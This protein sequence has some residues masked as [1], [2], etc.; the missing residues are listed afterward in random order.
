MDPYLAV[1]ELIGPLS[2]SI[3]SELRILLRLLI[4][5]TEIYNL[6]K[7]KNSNIVSFYYRTWYLF[8][9][10]FFSLATKYVQVGLGPGYGQIRNHLACWIRIRKIYLRMDVQL[11]STCRVLFDLIFLV[12]RRSAGGTA[13]A[14]CCR[15]RVY[16]REPQIVRDLALPR[17]RGGGELDPHCAYLVSLSWYRYLSRVCQHN[18]VLQNAKW[19][20][21]Y[22]TRFGSAPKCRGSPTL[23]QIKEY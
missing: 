19:F 22:G 9:D 20:Y 10:I 2:V 13:Q 11:H 6:F 7:A 8:D 4:L 23:R 14:P 17:R 15:S 3:N 1:P 12:E 18:T 5:I 16:S 21:K